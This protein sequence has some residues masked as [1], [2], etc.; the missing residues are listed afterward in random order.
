M[1]L[2]AWLSAAIG[3][4]TKRLKEP[5]AGGSSLAFGEVRCAL[6]DAS[7]AAVRK[8]LRATCQRKAI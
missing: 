5:P 2:K 1:L 7:D 8:K 3:F 6:I 4:F